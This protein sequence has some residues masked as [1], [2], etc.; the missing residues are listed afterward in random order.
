MAY[1]SYSKFFSEIDGKCAMYF[2]KTYPSPVHF[3]EKTAEELTMEFKE[4]SPIIRK[5]KAEI[6][7]DCVK[8][9][10]NTFSRIP[11]IQGLYYNKSGKRLGTSE[12]RIGRA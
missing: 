6:I 7:L 5:D 1:P 10:G 3:E 9:D 8:N 11:G 2:W 4:I 12:R